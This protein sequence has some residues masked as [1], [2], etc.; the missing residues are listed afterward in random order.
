MTWLWIVLA[1]LLGGLVYGGERVLRARMQ[2]GVDANFL[3]ENSI[4]VTVPLAADVSA[5]DKA[6]RELRDVEFTAQLAGAVHKTFIDG[7]LTL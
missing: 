5:G 3:V 6:A 4:V 7:T 2:G 1:P